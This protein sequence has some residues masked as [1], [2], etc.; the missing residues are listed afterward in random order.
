LRAGYGAIIGVLIL[1]ALEAYRIQVNVSQQHVEIYRHFVEQ[2]EALTT[3][4]RNLWLASIYVR[5]FFIDPTPEQASG[6]TSLNL[7]VSLGA[8]ATLRGK[9]TLNAHGDVARGREWRSR[10]G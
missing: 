6:F 7:C 9:A 3:L 8:S 2:D 10:F 5:D 1:P 4:R